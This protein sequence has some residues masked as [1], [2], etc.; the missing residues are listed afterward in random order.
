MSETHD[1]ANA[2]ALGDVVNLTSTSDLLDWRLFL[3]LIPYAASVVSVKDGKILNANKAVGR[4]FGYESD[5]FIGQ[6]FFSNGIFKDDSI[7]Q[8]IYDKMQGRLIKSDWIM[9]YYWQAQQPRIGSFSLRKVMH[10]DQLC[11]LLFC[12][13]ITK[14]NQKEESL[15]Q[16][17]AFYKTLVEHTQ[18]IPWQLDAQGQ[19]FYVGPG[20][21]Q[22][23]F[24]ADELVGK[25]LYQFLH[26][27]DK[28]KISNSLKSV[29]SGEVPPGLIRASIKNTHGKYTEVEVSSTPIFDDEKNIIGVHGIARDISDRIRIES[30]LRKRASLDSLTGLLNRKSFYRRLDYTLKNNA[31]FVKGIALFFIDVDDFKSI[32]DNL[33]H[34]TGDSCLKKI[35]G[36]IKSV[37]R[38]TDSASRIGGDEFAILINPASIDIINNICQ[39]IKHQIE[40]LCP[41]NQ[42]SG[43]EL[44]VSMGI[45]LAKEKMRISNIV[46]SADKAMYTAKKQGKNCFHI[47]EN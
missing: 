9:P 46:H 39:R 25:S 15:E 30:R 33:G 7:Q 32:N 27:K 23:G 5:Q 12:N 42:L 24:T 6:N 41:V 1:L 14:T 18:D 8:Q 17:L 29:I 40:I 34:N 28:D 22:W 38:D 2:M 3:D 19:I 21:K 37:I 35:A 11:Y 47:A 16:R 43:H 10:Q 31:L 36:I 13:D 26:P 44:T 20:V 4:I 45:C